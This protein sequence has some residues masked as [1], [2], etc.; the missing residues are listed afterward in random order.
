MNEEVD[1]NEAIAIIGMAGRFPGAANIDKYWQNL[2]DGT[3]SSTTFSRDELLE[4]GGNA[5]HILNENYVPS[6]PVLEN[7]DRFD[8][9]FFKY[10]PYD[11][12][13]IDPQQR[14]LLEVAWLAFEDAG[15]DPALTEGRVATFAGTAMNTYML[16]TGLAKHF[17]SD[18][19][20]TLLGSDKDYV[21]TRIAYKLGL[22]GPAATVQ[23]A[24]STSLVAIHMA[25]QS[26]LE[27]ESDMALVGASS[28]RCPLKTGH[29]YQEGSVFSPDGVCRPFDAAAAGT[30]FGSGVGAVLLKRL[31]DAEQDG[32]NIYA[33]VKGSAINN[34]GDTKSDFTAPTVI[35]Q[36]EVILESM[37]S[38]GVSADTIGYV[39]AHGTGTYLGDPI[40]VEA[41]TKAYRLD[42]EENNF[43]A[44]GSVKGNIGHLDAAAGL[45]SLIKVTKALD[46]RMIPASANFTAPN[47]QI[48]FASTPFRVAETTSEW[49]HESEIPRRAGISSLGMGGTNSHVILEEYTAPAR[50]GTGDS[51]PVIVPLSAVSTSAL[52]NSALAL[53][54]QLQADTPLGLEDIGH[55]LQR[56]RKALPRRAALVA[57]SIQELQATLKERK[58]P[59][60]VMAEAVTGAD[61]F[62]KIFMFPGQGSQYAAMGAS[63]YRTEPVFKKYVDLAD[64]VSKAEFDVSMIDLLCDPEVRDLNQTYLT[65]PAL[66]VCS[67]AYARL[68]EAWGFEADRYIG[69]SIGEFVAAALAGVFS[70]EDGLR[71][72]MHRG[73]LMQSA[74][75]GSMLMLPL[76]AEKAADTL[77]DGIELAVINNTSAC[78]VAGS[79]QDILA[80]KEKYESESLDCRVLKT[81]HAFHT[82]MMDEAA[83]AFEQ[84]VAKIPL[85]VPEKPFISCVTGDWIDADE[86]ISPSYWASQIRQ[87]VNFSKAL[88]SAFDLG[89]AWFIE[90]GP[91]IVLSQ[92]AGAHAARGETHLVLASGR[93]PRVSDPEEIVA[94]RMLCQFWTLGGALDW[95]LVGAE[96]HRVSLPGYLFEGKPHWF[97]NED[98]ASAA[99]HFKKSDNPQD[100]IWTDSWSHYRCAPIDATERHYY[101]LDSANE[102]AGLAQALGA[103]GAAVSRFNEVAD[104]VEALGA[105]PADTCEVVYCPAAGDFLTPDDLVQITT[106]EFERIRC[107]A[108]ACRKKLNLRVVQFGKLAVFEEAGIESPASLLLGMLP[109]FA[110]EYPGVSTQLIEIRSDRDFHGKLADA[111]SRP[112]EYSVIALDGNRW[113]F[114]HYEQQHCFE[115]ATDALVENQCNVVVGAFGGIG[116]HVVEHLAQRAGKLILVG[117]KN[118]ERLS[119]AESLRRPGLEVS[120]IEVD[121]ALESQCD[122]IYAELQKSKQYQPGSI[123]H[124]AGTTRDSLISGKNID[125]FEQTLRAKVNGTQNLFGVTSRADMRLVLFS[126]TAAFSGP[127]GQVDYAAANAFQLQFALNNSGVVAVAWP[128]WEGTGLLADVKDTEA[129]KRIAENSVTPA[130]GIRVLETVLQNSDITELAVVSTVSPNELQRSASGPESAVG[131]LESLQQNLEPIDVIASEVKKA[132]RIDELDPTDNV[133]AMGGSSL[134]VVTLLASLRS[135]FGVTLS[136]NEALDNPTPEAWAGLFEAAQKEELTQNETSVAPSGSDDFPKIVGISRYFDKRAGSNFDHWNLATLLECQQAMKVDQIETSLVQLVNHHEMLKARIVRDSSG[137]YSVVI[138][139]RIDGAILEQ[140]DLSAVDDNALSA[141]IEERA[142]ECHQQ[143]SL[144]DT[145]LFKCVHF[146][147]G[148]TRADRL[149][150]LVHHFV[151]DGLSWT[152]VLSDFQS[153]LSAVSGG[154]QI[155]LPEATTGYQ[156]WA[157]VQDLRANI[158]SAPHYLHRWS[159]LPW[160]TVG[161]IPDL[162][163][164]ENTNDSAAH[165]SRDLDPAVSQRILK[166]S[167]FGATSELLIVALAKAISGWARCSTGDGVLMDVLGNGRALD[168]DYDV[169]RTVGFFNSYSPV[170]INPDVPLTRSA[171]KDLC[172]DVRQ[173]VDRENEYDRTKY[174]SRDTQVRD[175]MRQ[176]PVARVLFNYIGNLK[177]S[178]DDLLDE[179]YFKVAHESAGTLHDSSARRDHQLAFRVELVDDRLNITLVY[180]ENM[181]D[182]T[183]V[184]QLISMYCDQLLEISNI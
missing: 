38:A 66:Y 140:V 108:D 12:Q 149:L 162:S 161:V 30:V 142:N 21:A 35:K 13:L 123:Y 154:N 49:Q 103:R 43:C 86:A 31:D 23:T 62:Q 117:R 44:L 73:R 10:S 67:Y 168:R 54:Q 65:Q 172:F 171:L 7:A 95:A 3:V 165:I 70:Y 179:R 169:T 177:N 57:N 61:R 4:A 145:L 27:G 32:D 133:L 46:S 79:E 181:N 130:L 96:G 143:F 155:A 92:I 39:E 126:S 176:L 97:V 166:A 173:M 170:L 110:S 129:L 184:E 41:L 56:G 151:A 51:G 87:P 75:K 9:E 1:E 26:L 104:L 163:Q 82:S 28:I 120:T 174:L 8:A 180:S 127:V 14:Q 84:E 144:S 183:G 124:L 88:S 121:I 111:L 81:S 167:G 107:I 40:E 114:R 19:L 158:E 20:P 52:K 132:L 71:L 115:R 53:A 147:C 136:L 77:P 11:A 141:C 45:A 17:F 85:L 36:A 94:R 135:Q 164:G 83:I 178:N 134:M 138:R 72:V 148:P 118:Q 109:V 2:L 152:I 60:M 63:L 80:A 157:R 99:V 122:A 89:G 119:F 24:C 102:L 160:G 55:T 5:D 34:D 64:S 42:T 116:R 113:W 50:T 47:P 125:E 33:V 156:E 100:W 128:G 6:A 69:H 131:E 153:I 98:E 68:L 74:P 93:H 48:D 159:E 29:L 139:E 105:T 101:F 137:D 150:L 25:R 76:P 175:F 112:V 59:A 106:Q 146:N 16:H 37:E 182:R 15:Y 22:K 78:V 91:G 18:Y 58:P 90:A